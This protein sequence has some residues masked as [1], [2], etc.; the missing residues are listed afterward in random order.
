MCGYSLHNLFLRREIDVS[1]Q[2]VSV[3][4]RSPYLAAT[5]DE[6]LGSYCRAAQGNG[7]R[8]RAAH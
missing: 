1:Q 4:G 7:A 8:A 3:T 2:L 6:D 5:Q